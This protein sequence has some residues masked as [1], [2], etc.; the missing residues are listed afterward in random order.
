VQLIAVRCHAAAAPSSPA[1]TLDEPG[2]TPAHSEPH[3][4]ADRDPPPV[5]LVERPISRR[6]PRARPRLPPVS[7]HGVILGTGARIGASDLRRSNSPRTSLN[8]STS[9]AVL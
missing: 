6:A 4:D 2:D 3:Y 5:R 9:R 8:S 1:A 7:Q